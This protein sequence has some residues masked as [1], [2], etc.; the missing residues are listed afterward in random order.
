MLRTILQRLKSLTR[1]MR[2]KEQHQ[3][4]IVPTLNNNPNEWSEGY[5]L[6]QRE[7]TGHIALGIFS[8]VYGSQNVLG[9]FRLR[10]NKDTGELL[11]IENFS[12]GPGKFK[13]NRT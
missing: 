11:A 1:K 10:F 2:V 8:F 3:S 12:P 7:D 13:V 9:S 6:Y 4:I 5:C